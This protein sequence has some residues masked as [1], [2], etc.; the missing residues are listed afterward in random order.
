[1]DPISSKTN[2]LLVEL[3]AKKRA[4]SKGNL[5]VR[6]AKVHRKN[7]ADIAPRSWLS[8]HKVNRTATF[9]FPYC[10]KVESDKQND[11]LDFVHIKSH[12]KQ[13]QIQE[14]AVSAIL[15]VNMFST[16]MVCTGFRYFYQCE[17]ENTFSSNILLS[18]E[19]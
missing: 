17:F 19:L 9:H 16:T 12:G 10:S 8:D 1:M 6:L 14:I 3:A 2:C 11:K 18:V 5:C 4:K 7:H 15:Y 13:D